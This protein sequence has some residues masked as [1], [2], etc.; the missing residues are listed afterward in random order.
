MFKSIKPALL[1]LLCLTMLTGIVYPLTILISAQI[2]FPGQA[3]GSLLYD[4]N[5][6]VGSEL[7]GQ[8]FSHPGYFWGRPSATPTSSY[9][10]GASGASNLGPTNS[11]LL[12]TVQTRIKALR[13]ADPGNTN[14]IPVDLLTASGSGL[15]PHISPAAALFQVN[16]VARA[17][18]L[19]NDTVRKIVVQFTESRQW[20]VLG[21]TR[22]NVLA[23]NLALN[24]HFAKSNK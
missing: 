3:N 9:N 14:P 11:A 24:Q 2:L 21:E 19:S 8:T 23:M 10:G 15:D 7:I 22:I 12:D 1:M 18:N 20:H 16:R 13:D 5:Q 4:K 6:V 17:R